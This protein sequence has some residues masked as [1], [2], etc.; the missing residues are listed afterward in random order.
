MN[1]FIFVLTWASGLILEKIM[2]HNLGGDLL[3]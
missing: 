2:A 3:S 1:V